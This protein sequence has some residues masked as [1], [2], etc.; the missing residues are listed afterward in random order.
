MHVFYYKVSKK[1]MVVCDRFVFG[2]RNLKEFLYFLI[3]M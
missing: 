2:S 1:N 3:S